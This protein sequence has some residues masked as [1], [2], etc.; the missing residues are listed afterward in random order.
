M[1]ASL[2]PVGE[3]ARNRRWSV[4]ATAH[5][6]G[7]ALGG[8][9]AFGALG[10]LGGVA[11]GLAAIVPDAG[12]PS[13]DGQR[14]AL[15]V[16]GLLTLV[17]LVVDR[18]PW[19]VPTW[20]RQVDERWLHAYRGWVY[21][22]GYGAQL[23][24]GPVTITTSTLT[25]LALATAALTGS[26]SRGALIGASYGV[27]RALPLLLTA[28]VRTP[29]A[30]RRLHRRLDGWRRPAGWVATAGQAGVVATAAV[31]VAGGAA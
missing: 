3:A 22:L 9:A 17:G 25:Y 5:L 1:L 6:V 30:L 4:T 20:R 12:G 24:L 21:G 26:A 13:V 14:A 31:A 18:G 7:S 16:L 29:A 28:P 27:A 10:A 15:A 8:I 11:A 19:S 2:S 23:G